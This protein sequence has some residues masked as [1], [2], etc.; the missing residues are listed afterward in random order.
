MKKHNLNK[1]EKL[2]SKAKRQ[3]R[4]NARGKQWKVS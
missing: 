1:S 4:K 3:E 2:A